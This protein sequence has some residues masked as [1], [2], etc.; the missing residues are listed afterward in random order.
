MTS[1]TVCW[2]DNSL[3]EAQFITQ[4]SPPTALL[5]NSSSSSSSMWCSNIYTEDTCYKGILPGGSDGK[6]SACN[7]GGLGSIPESGRSGEENGNPLQS[8]WLENPMDR[9]AWRATV[10]GSQRVEH[11]SDSHFHFTC[12][13]PG[14]VL[15]AVKAGYHFLRIDFL[16]FYLFLF[17]DFTWDTTLHLLVMSP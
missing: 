3:S 14:S 5:L 10:L 13:K 16:S 1:I 4:P 15:R 7:A 17:Q 11:D 2:P 12:Y 6:E 9:G 8:S